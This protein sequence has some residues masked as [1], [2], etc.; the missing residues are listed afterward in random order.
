M[1]IL[2]FMLGGCAS[3]PQAFLAPPTELFADASFAPP[4]KPVDAS[5]LFTLSPEMR[6][7]LHSA[8]F[9][10]LMRTM[11]KE[12]G[13]IEALYTK[14]DLK[15]EYESSYTRTA[16]ETFRDRVGNC[17]SLVIMTAAFAKE[18]NIPVRFQSVDMESWSRSGNYYL[19][20]GHVNIMLGSRTDVSDALREHVLVVDFL[21]AAQADTLGAHLIS[22][23]QIV[24]MFQNNR[25]AEAL[26]DGR[27][28]DA[29]W[30]ARAAVA[31]N[32]ASA[33]PLNTLAVIYDHHGDKPMA[34]RVYRAALQREPENLV[35]LRNLEPVL[36]ALGKTDEAQAIGKRLASLEPVPP[37]QYFHQGVAAYQERKYDKARDLFRREIKRA[38]YND[39]FHFWLAAT[40]LQLD[41]LA[42][43][44][45]ELALAVDNSTQSDIR[46]RYSAKLAHLRELGMH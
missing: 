25:A 12:K 18:L 29:Y 32:P 8:A 33:M 31:R 19:L 30:W 3:T 37:F 14:G 43:A 44:R 46:K 27:L 13:L 5:S 17:M 11:G 7:Y 40:Y 34:E 22:E 4:S 1:I 38:P 28:D 41:R 6:T 2:L 10:N 26:V 15:L 9:G 45:N 16:A 20:S 39:E 21:P 24:S 23:D 42:D 35:T 36:A